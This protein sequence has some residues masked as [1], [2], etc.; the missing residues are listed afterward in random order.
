MYKNDRTNYWKNF[1]VAIYKFVVIFLYCS[2]HS[3]R[4]YKRYKY[5]L[6]D[7]CV[8]AQKFVSERKRR[9]LRLRISC[10]LKRI[11][12]ASAKFFP[13]RLFFSKNISR[14]SQWYNCRKGF[15]ERRSFHRCLSIKSE[16]CF[17]SIHR[18]ARRPSIR[19][20]PAFRSTIPSLFAAHC[21][22]E[23]SRP[24]QQLT[25]VMNAHRI[26]G[27]LERDC[28]K[29]SKRSCAFARPGLFS[30]SATSFPSS[31]L[32]IL[33]HSRRSFAVDSRLKR[34]RSRR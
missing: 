14:S 19:K 10:S 20:W 34:Q 32:F 33:S 11:Y 8:M 29:Q 15:W 22:G 23:A 12:Q 31:F 18:F 7:F 1:Y 17:Y 28:K 25:T 21:H 3:T 4:W 9:I 13:Y 2:Y 24:K 26:P 27:N 16:L 30:T 6:K 5:L